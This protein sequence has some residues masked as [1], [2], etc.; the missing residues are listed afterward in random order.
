MCYPHDSSNRS[1][2]IEDS[3]PT[4]KTQNMWVICGIT[5]MGLNAVTKD[6]SS[7]KNVVVPQL[8]CVFLRRQKP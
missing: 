8:C 6:G 2:K 7:P 5:T 1:K 4:I 3:N